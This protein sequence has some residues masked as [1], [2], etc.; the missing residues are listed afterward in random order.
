M[1]PHRTFK[2]FALLFAA[3]MFSAN[4]MAEIP[5]LSIETLKASPYIITGTVK[6]IKKQDE[7]LNKC[8]VRV[9]VTL[10]VKPDQLKETAGAKSGQVPD[11]LIRGYLFDFRCADQLRPDGPTGIWDLASLREGS[12]VTIHAFRSKSDGSLIILAPNG[13]TLIR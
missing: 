7:F 2:T 10:I 4:L 11:E 6:S 13:L 3:L 12:R 1:I 9:D 8:Q 5:P